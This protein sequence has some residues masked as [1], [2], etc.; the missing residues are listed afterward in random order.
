MQEDIKIKRAILRNA[1]AK[2]VKDL[3][4]KQKK[5][6]TLISDEINLS[7][8]IWADAEKGIVDFQFSTFWRIS[9]ALDIKPEE[10]IIKLKKNLPE[11]FSF[12]DFE[13]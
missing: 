13:N 2:T 5:S 8:T 1:I 3:R 11:D 12:L 7:K 9:E 10:F 6:I 4:T